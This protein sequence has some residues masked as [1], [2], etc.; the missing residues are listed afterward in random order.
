MG[1]LD[2]EIQKSREIHYIMQDLHRF[3][4]ISQISRDSTDF[5]GI[6]RCIMAFRISGFLDFSWI[7][8]VGVRDFFLVVDPSLYILLHASFLIFTIIQLVVR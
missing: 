4:E 2:F 1:F 6:S 8:A 5:S 3:P 7:F